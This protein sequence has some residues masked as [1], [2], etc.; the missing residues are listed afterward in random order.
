M[1][2]SS[3]DGDRFQQALWAALNFNCYLVYVPFNS[4]LLA[5]AALYDHHESFLQHEQKLDKCK[6]LLVLPS[7]IFYHSERVRRTGGPHVAFHFRPSS[8]C[9]RNLRLQIPQK[10]LSPEVQGDRV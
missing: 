2:V 6:Q 1:F 7:K 8:L 9:H 3:N 5:D 4:H 10:Y